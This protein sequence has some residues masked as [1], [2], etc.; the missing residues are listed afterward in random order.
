MEKYEELKQAVAEMDVDVQKFAK[1]NHA[2]GTRLRKSLQN[3][4]RI[5]QEMRVHVQEQKKSDK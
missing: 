1:G 4:K 5:A 3:V 2:A